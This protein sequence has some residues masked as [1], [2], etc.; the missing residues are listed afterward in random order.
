MMIKPD[1]QHDGNN[2]EYN[3]PLGLAVRAFQKEFT[4]VERPNSNCEHHYS[5]ER[6]TRETVSGQEQ[7]HPSFLPFF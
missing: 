6:W 4:K 1:S 5:I 7:L 2:V 3:I